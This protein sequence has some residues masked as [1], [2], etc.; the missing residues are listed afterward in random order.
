MASA[1]PPPPPDDPVSR[2]ID[3]ARRAFV[4]EFPGDAAA[5]G[6]REIDVRRRGDGLAVSFPVRPADGDRRWRGHRPGDPPEPT[7]EVSPDGTVLG[8]S[9]AR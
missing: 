5:L 4:D 9:L 3:A 6:R 8:R 2:A 1:G 7:C